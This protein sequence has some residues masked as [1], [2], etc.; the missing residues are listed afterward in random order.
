ME[1]VIPT[2]LICLVLWL[3][4]SWCPPDNDSI[5]EQFE[6]IMFEPDEKDFQ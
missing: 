4:F 2:V 6:P 1:P 3:A 5:R